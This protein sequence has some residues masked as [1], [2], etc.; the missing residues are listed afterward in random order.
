MNRQVKLEEIAL[1]IQ[2]WLDEQEDDYRDLN[3]NLTDGSLIISPLVF[4][5][6]GTLQEWVKVLRNEK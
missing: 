1:Q 6:R 4:P 2:R 3:I 5:S